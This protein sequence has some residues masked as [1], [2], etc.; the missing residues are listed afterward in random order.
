M[1]SE[2]GKAGVFLSR[3]PFDRGRRE[4]LV[5]VG[6]L[7]CGAVRCGAVAGANAGSSR[8]RLTRELT[9]CPKDALLE[10]MLPY[11]MAVF[12]QNPSV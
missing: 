11:L 3:S 10:K 8:G 7:R 12:G 5:A 4:M 9:S 2:V 6:S 1:S